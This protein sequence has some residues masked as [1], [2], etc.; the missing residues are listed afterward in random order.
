MDEP[1]AYFRF[2]E[3]LNDFLPKK[4]EKKTFPHGFRGTPSAKTAIEA[5]GIPHTEVDLIIANGK[6]VGFDYQINADDRISVYPVFESLD[7]SP[8]IR[9]RKEPLRITKFILDVHL[10]KLANLLRMLGFD[11][12]YQNN[13]QDSEIVQTALKQNRIILTRDVN[14]LKR[15]SVTHGYWMRSTKV[16]EQLKEVIQRFDIKSQIQPFTRCLMCNTKIKKIKKKE[17]MNMIPPNTRKYF[18][19]FY[20]CSQCNKVYWKGSHYKRMI[21]K[22]EHFLE[23]A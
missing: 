17:I 10:G 2:Y 13:Y 22:M 23:T 9:L 4:W 1:V 3:E 14:L 20:F 16:G 12:M 8:I 6:S 15:K 21:Q 5:I 18:H 7:I 11:T 19:E